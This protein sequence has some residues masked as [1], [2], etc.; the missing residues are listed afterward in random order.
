MVCRYNKS[1][2]KIRDQHASMTR[3]NS[4]RPYLPLVLLLLLLWGLLTLH[5]N[6]P[7]YGHHDANG[8]WIGAAARNLRVYGVGEIGLVPLLNRSL[9]PPGTPNYYVHHPPLIVW[10][11]ALAES[12]FGPHEMSA[13]L[14]S[15]FSTLISAAAFYVFCRRLYGASR[16][17]TCTLLYS[18]TPMI[19]YFGRMPNHEPLSLAFTLL[20]AAVFARWL[21]EPARWRGGLLLSLAALSVWSAWAPLLI[22]LALCAVGWW[23]AAASQRWRLIALALGSGA[24][25]V[26][27]P[28]FY[29]LYRPDTLD[30]LANAFLWR[31]SNRGETAATFT[32]AEFFQ[33]QLV[34]LLPH[35]TLAVMILALVGIALTIHHERGFH[36]MI[37]L[38][39]LLAGISYNLIFR[40]AAYV[41]DYYKIYL[42]PALAILAANAIFYLL[43]R[44]NIRRF[45]HPALVGLFIT[46]VPFSVIYGSRLY[47]DAEVARFN[48]DLAQHIASHSAPEDTVLTNLPN[49]NPT[50]EYYAFRYVLW[51][52]RPENAPD[53]AANSPAVYLFCPWAEP[54]SNLEP[55]VE[56][57]EFTPVDFDR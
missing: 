47:G 15:A 32:W 57:C 2:L 37:V 19:A 39:L 25:A 50:V 6:L 11:V 1:V 44:A 33:E 8:V 38:A 21:R 40:S 34:H 36:R 12:V 27:V 52:V 54:D 16:A 9:I 56:S 14:V 5:M 7:W 43:R 53:R 45:A 46:S 3:H 51:N 35:A 24:A 17:L 23:Y 18:F 28:L 55:T 31:T 30:R 41:H 49:H 42:M 20:F 22:V 48:L 29:S 10:L 4:N 26:A 13:R